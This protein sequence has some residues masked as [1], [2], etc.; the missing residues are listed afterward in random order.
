MGRDGK[1]LDKTGRKLLLQ[2]RGD[3]FKCLHC[4]NEVPTKALSTVHRNHCP[5]CL[6]SRHVDVSIGDRKSN[7]LCSME[8]IGLT[9]KRD[10]GELMIV[11]FCRGCGKISKNRIS[12]DDN[13]H[14]IVALFESSS[15]TSTTMRKLIAEN[16][17][18]LCGNIDQIKQIIR[19][20]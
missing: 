20:T 8:P 13:N 12:A 4:R 1:R 11:H 6:W 14:I 19:V 7:C 2:A 18:E 17:I 15:N 16:G 9:I 5:L 10:G 3:S